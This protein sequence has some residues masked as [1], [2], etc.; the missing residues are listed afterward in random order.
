VTNER[1]GTSVERERRFAENGS[2]AEAKG[3][4]RKKSRRTKLLIW[5]LVDAIVLAT[6][7]GLLF[8]RPRGY[9][10]VIAPLDDDD[11]VHPYIHRELYST[12]Y[13]GAQSQEPFDLEVLEEPLNEAVAQ[14]G[15]PQQSEGIALSAPE[16]AFAEGRI[17]LMGTADVEGAEF[18][19]TIELTPEIGEQGLLT[20]SVTKVRVGAMNVTPLAKMMARKMYRE[21]LEL[22]PVDTE[23]LRSKI[24]ASLLAEQSFDPVFRF[25]DKWVRLKEFD[26]TPGRI[27]ARLVP[28]PRGQ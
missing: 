16:I 7:L 13:N 9:D 14:A 22:A 3:P 23:D 6:V 25:E 8:Y 26:I 24:V 4:G 17:V 11:S 10:P 27:L 21:R 1:F 20:V 12:L 15:W 19:V 2:G 5:L 28:A 18:I